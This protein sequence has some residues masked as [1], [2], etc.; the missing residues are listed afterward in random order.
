MRKSRSFLVFMALMSWSLNPF[1]VPVA[2]SPEKPPIK[3]GIEA[4]IEGQSLP[5]TSPKFGFPENK[6]GINLMI[7]EYPSNTVPEHLENA[8]DLVG[9]GWVKAFSPS[10]DDPYKFSLFVREAEKRG[11]AA[12]LR[13]GGWDRPEPSDYERIALAYVDFIRKINLLAGEKIRFIEV[14]N[15]PN[16]ESEWGGRPSGAE[17]GKFLVSVARAFK[18]FDPD[19]KVLN[20]G[21]AVTDGT[22]D[23]RNIR[24]E[25]FI[26][27]MFAAAPELVTYLDTWSS[28]PY[29]QD[30]RGCNPYAKSASKFCFGAYDHELSVISE[31]YERAGLSPPRIIITETS[32]N[33]GIGSVS[34]GEFYTPHEFGEAVRNYWLRDDRVIGF[35]PF[36]FTRYPSGEWTA[37]EFADPGRG[38]KTNEYY[39]VLKMLRLEQGAILAGHR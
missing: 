8:H 30:F 2:G 31:Y 6:F 3:Q 14:R 22:P 25:N 29:P 21:L 32:W 24:T 23:G 36:A 16:L 12:L 17:Y 37:Y 13:I 5:D 38:F 18:M 26:R 11:M 4:V 20:A 39:S 33:P 10:L 9:D 35:L 19:V 7:H 27:D 28:H 15:E 1:N 34:R